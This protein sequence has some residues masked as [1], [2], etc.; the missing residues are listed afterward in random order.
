MRPR[1][2]FA[3]RRSGITSRSLNSHRFRVPN[4]PRQHGWVNWNTTTVSFLSTIADSS[5]KAYTSKDI[6]TALAYELNVTVPSTTFVSFRLQDI[7]VYDVAG[8]ALSL[9]LC[10]LERASNV[11]DSTNYTTTSVCYPARNGWASC[12]AKWSH[13]D[14]TTVLKVSPGSTGI[15]NPYL[16][17]VFVDA[18][19]DTTLVP[20]EVLVKVN[21]SWRFSAIVGP[22]GLETPE[23]FS[24]FARMRALDLSKVSTTEEGNPLLN[25]PT[26]S[27]GHVSE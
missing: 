26:P 25:I 1:R 5:Y 18:L 4:V 12:G 3:R 10:D 24:P 8:R 23:N 16:F 13:K 9:A 17:V 21:V 6:L 15:D 20:L 19:S 7:R 14:Q 27:V 11:Q 22:N 2:R